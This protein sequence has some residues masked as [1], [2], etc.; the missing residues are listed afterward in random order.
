MV[1]APVIMTLASAEP[2]AIPTSALP[3]TAVWPGPP[4][5]T[6]LPNLPISRKK[7]LAPMISRQEPNSTSK[8]PNSTIMPRIFPKIPEP[9]PRQIVEMAA[10]KAMRV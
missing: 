2:E 10:A 6:L 4:L 5:L 3:M 9:K 7:T 1:N 8:K